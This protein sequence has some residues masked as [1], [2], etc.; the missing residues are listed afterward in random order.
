MKNNEMKEL[1]FN[2]GLYLEMTNRQINGR[3][4]QQIEINS[5]MM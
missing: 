3:L 4:K 5:N 2:S 1:E